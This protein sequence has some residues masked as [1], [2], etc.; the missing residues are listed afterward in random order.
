MAG[1]SDDRP[2]NNT[3]TE[4]QPPSINQQPDNSGSGIYL[5]EPNIHRTLFIVGVHGEE[6]QGAH[7]HAITT[8]PS[9]HAANNESVCCR[10]ATAKSGARHEQGDSAN[11]KI[12][13]IEKAE[14]SANRKDSGYAS[15]QEAGS[16]HV[17]SISSHKSGN[18]HPYPT[19]ANFEASPRSSI[20]FLR[21]S[22]VHDP[23]ARRDRASQE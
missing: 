20:T 15:D 3:G 13:R 11:V 7:V 21:M 10:C 12:L 1:A 16:F 19:H 4:D 18:I 6:R 17:V 2:T 23:L 5:R 8:Q 14:K 9:N 22:S